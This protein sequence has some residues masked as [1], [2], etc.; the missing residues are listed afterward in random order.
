MHQLRWYTA[1]YS[2]L[3]ILKI[4]MKELGFVDFKHDKAINLLASFQD[5]LLGWREPTLGPSVCTQNAISSD[6]YTAE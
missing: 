1:K 3:A 5:S 4:I 6:I 2:I